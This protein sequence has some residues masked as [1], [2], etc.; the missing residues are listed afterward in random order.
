[1]LLNYMNYILRGGTAIPGHHW[2]TLDFKDKFIFDEV[3]LDWEAAYAKDYRIEGRNGID[4]QDDDW[5]V[6][7]DGSVP[8]HKEM[9][10]M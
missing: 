8:P 10:E 4:G 2:V 9:Y 3:V 5:V 6:L 7:Y 1:M